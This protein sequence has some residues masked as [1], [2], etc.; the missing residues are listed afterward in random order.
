VIVDFRLKEL[1]A[2]SFQLS[3]VS[4]KRKWK[5]EPGKPAIDPYLFPVPIL[6]ERGWLTA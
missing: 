4:K 2:V 3:A 6:A 5:L 1:S